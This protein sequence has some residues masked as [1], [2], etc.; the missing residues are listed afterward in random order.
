MA[1]E[2]RG[3]VMVFNLPTLAEMQSQRRALRKDQIPTRL[4]AR[5]E[6]DRIDHSKLDKWRKEIHARDGNRCRYSRVKVERTLRLQPNRCECHHIEP[7]SNKITRYDRRNGLQVSFMV[8]E[9]IERGDLRLIGTRFFQA[10]DG[11]SYINADF[12]I[13]VL[14]WRERDHRT[15]GW[16]FDKV[17]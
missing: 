12:P 11:S 15:H 16:V 5:K 10:D 3:G 8:H 2:I 17:I 9:R 6:D 13:I 1:R 7:R 14:Q 4:D